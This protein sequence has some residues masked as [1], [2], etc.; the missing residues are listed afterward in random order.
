MRTRQHPM[1]SRHLATFEDFSLLGREALAA[2]AEDVRGRGVRIR[3]AAG[4]RLLR[5]LREE[6]KHVLHRLRLPGTTLAGDAHA[7]ALLVRHLG[8]VMQFSLLSSL[9]ISAQTSPLYMRPTKPSQTKPRQAKPNQAKPSREHDARPD[10]A[11]LNGTTDT[12]RRHQ[13][14]V[15]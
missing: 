9:R 13:K 5:N 1:P 6:V 11:K 12:T 7:L 4:A 14:V 15:R 8:W 3:R 2:P 10:Q